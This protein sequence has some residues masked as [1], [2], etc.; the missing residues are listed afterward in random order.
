MAEEYMEERLTWE[1]HD[2]G[3]VE[4]QDEN[5][6]SVIIGGLNRQLTEHVQMNDKR[7]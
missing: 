4:E 2:R 7:V 6:E 3:L 5:V 1:M